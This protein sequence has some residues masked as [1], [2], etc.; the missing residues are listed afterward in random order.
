MKSLL[1][2]KERYLRNFAS[3]VYDTYRQMRYGLASCQFQVDDMLASIRYDLLQWQSVDDEG[4][5]TE[6]SFRVWTPVEYENQPQ[7]YGGTG[8]VYSSQNIT[9]VPQGGTAQF[10]TEDGQTI[11]EVNSGGCITRINL[12]PVINMSGTTT[13][14]N[15]VWT[16]SVANTTWTITH[17]LGYNPVVRTEDL[18]GT[19]IEGLITYISVNQLSILF[20][21]P[22]TGVAYLS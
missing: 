19:D 18:N 15:F 13:N 10:M 12:S 6:V 4:A 8:Y 14:D 16:Q 17:N 21:E 3:S 11:L 5:L 9:P 20:S 7:I 2:N 22:V 1:P